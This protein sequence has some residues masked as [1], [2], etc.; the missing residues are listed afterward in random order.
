M[1]AKILV[2]NNI[3]AQDNIYYLYD[4]YHY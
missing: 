4:F 2:V 1:G 3:V